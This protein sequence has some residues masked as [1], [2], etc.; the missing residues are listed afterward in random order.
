MLPLA[1]GVVAEPAPF[2]LG[3]VGVEPRRAGGDRV[4]ER[5]DDDQ[6]RSFL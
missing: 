2:A 4:A 6:P 5:A 3:G 1:L